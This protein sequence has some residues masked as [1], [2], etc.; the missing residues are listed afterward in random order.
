MA[1]PVYKLNY[2][3]KRI[4]RTPFVTY[5][6]GIVSK[7]RKRSCCGA[8]ISPENRSTFRI[9]GVRKDCNSMYQCHPDIWLS[10]FTGVRE[11]EVLRGLPRSKLG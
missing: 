4:V 5:D 2:S 1:I 3:V 10:S 8:A 6:H 9:V 7:L 11:V